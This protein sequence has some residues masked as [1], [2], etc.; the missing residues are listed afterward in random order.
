MATWK[1][2]GDAAKGAIKLSTNL[3]RLEVARNPHHVLGTLYSKTLRALAKMPQDYAYRKHTEAVSSS[4]IEP[5]KI[6]INDFGSAI[7]DTYVDESSNLP[8]Y[9]L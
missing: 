1:A 8:F 4:S 7:K 5:T 9:S 6:G 3:T 2:A